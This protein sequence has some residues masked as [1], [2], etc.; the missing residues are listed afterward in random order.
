VRISVRAVFFE[1]TQI[2]QI[3]GWI[4][5]TLKLYYQPGDLVIVND[6]G[7]PS[8]QKVNWSVALVMAIFHLG[9][10]AALFVFSWQLFITTVFL[11][12]LTTG[13]GISMGYHRLH[14]HR[15]Y[16]VPIGLEYFFAVC[17]ALTLEG[18]PISWVATHR[19]HHQKSDL[20]GDPHSPR[21]GAWWAHAGWLLTGKT[22]HSNTKAMSKYAP[23][24]A[25]DRF[26]VW[27]NNY[28]WVAN[29]VFALLLLAIGGIPLVLWGIF[30]RITFG[31]HATWAVNSATHMW[32]RR[33]FATRD[34]S[35]NNWWVAL[36]T[37]GEGWHNNH[38]AHPTSAR[39]GLAWY[40]FDPSWILIKILK[41]FGVAKSIR[42]ANV[43]SALAEREAA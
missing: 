37:F 40:E 9:A 8:N 35:R 34:D 4:A 11:Y 20:P 21:D 15:S 30:F 14:T 12:W 10:L 41:L 13:L 17:G 1:I 39:H 29:V 36:V 18:G 2:L 7:T 16:K 26:Y 28:H 6:F 5:A 3:A 32:G 42:V 22:N 25:K 27:L 43:T 23:D 33:R 24:L 19:M 38:H 31:L